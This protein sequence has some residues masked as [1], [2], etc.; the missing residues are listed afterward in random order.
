M[1][2]DWGRIVTTI[3]AHRGKIIGGLIGL[4]LGWLTIRYGFWRALVFTVFVL[5]GL[6]I[7]AVVDR[8][9]VDGLLERFAGRRR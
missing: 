5:V 9:G 6:G 2:I 3:W 1:Q 7:G 8:E 4:L